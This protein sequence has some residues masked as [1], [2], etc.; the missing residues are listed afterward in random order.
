[1]LKKNVI[2]QPDLFETGFAVM[3]CDGAS[4][5]N[6]G[7]SGIGVAI[8]INE[9]DADRLGIK[10]DYRISEY[11]GIATNNVA[12]YTA[13]IK[14][15][16]KARS[17]GIR[18]IKVFMDSELLARQINGLYR[19]RNEKLIPLWVQAKNILKDFDSYTVTHVPREMNKE[20]DSLARRAVSR[21]AS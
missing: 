4:S 21:A 3:H 20:A 5:G 15:L 9:E 2:I 10:G 18:K 6:P 19:V 7:K 14:G 11:I 1:M 17:L 12:E 16:E 13:L 8:T